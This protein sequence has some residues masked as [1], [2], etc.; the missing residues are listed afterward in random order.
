MRQPLQ[1]IP[2]FQ[3]WLALGALA[4]SAAD[5]SAAVADPP[6]PS[7]T[8]VAV[9]TAM[10]RARAQFDR[11]V[12]WLQDTKG[13]AATSSYPA[14]TEND[15]IE[16][17][18]ATLNGDW[19]L[20]D[21]K[22]WAAGHF[23]GLLWAMHH[24][25]QAASSRGAWADLAK[26][27]SEPLRANVTANPGDMAINCLHVFGPWYQASTASERAQQLGTVVTGSDLLVAPFAP[28]TSPGGRWHTGTGAMGWERRPD[29]NVD[30]DPAGATERNIHY[31][32]IFID[33]CGN[34]EQLLWAAARVPDA[35]KAADYRTKAIAHLVKV[36]SVMGS[37]RRPGTRGIWQRGFFDQDSAI[38]TGLS[39][40]RTRNDP[41]YTLG[42]FSFGQGKQGW[43]DGSTWSRGMGW[44]VHAVGVAYRETGDA[45]LR[46]V[47]IAAN[48]EWIARMPASAGYG[49]DWVAP[50]DFDY[51]EAG[52]PDTERDSSA[53]AMA[54]LGI[55]ATVQGLPQTHAKRRPYL[56]VARRTLDELCG[57]DYLVGA[58]DPEMS[59]LRH[60]CYHHPNALDDS[61]NYDNGLIWGDWFL[62]QSLLTWRQMT[63][64]NSAPTAPARSASTTVG[65]PVAIT[66]G[67]GDAENNPLGWRIVSPPAS[68]TITGTAPNLSYA[69]PA[70]WQGTAT[71]SYVVEDGIEDSAPAVVTV[72]VSAATNQAPTI[73]AIPAQTVAE[74][75]ATAALA[76]T[77]G[78]A[79][80]AAGSLTV[81]AA[82]GNATLVPS[83]GLTLGGSG[84]TRT[85]VVEPAANASG[86]ATITLTVSDGTSTATTSF[87][88]TVTP[89]NDAPTISAVPAQT[90]P[91]DGMTGALAFTVGDVETAA[92]SLTVSATSGNTTL[93]PAA[94]VTLGGSNSSRTVVIK[95]AAGASGSATIT[96]TVSD[97]TSSRTTSFLVTV[98]P[99]PAPEIAIARGATAI[100]DG[101]T[102]AAGSVTM[103][104]T[105]TLTYT[106]ANTGAAALG[107]ITPITATGTNCMVAVTQPGTSVAAGASTTAKL[108]VTP[109]AAGPWNVVVSI[110]T[111]DA[112]EN[113]S[114]WTITG[115][116]TAAAAIEVTIATTVDTA[117]ESPTGKGRVTLTRTGST[118][119]S[120]SVAL[121]LSG[122]ATAADY[123][124]IPTTAVIP[125]GSATLAIDIDPVADG[126]TEGGE[127]VM[128]TLAPPA[129]GA[130]Y[131]LGA[132][133][134]ASVTIF[135]VAPAP[136]PAP[137]APS[138]GD[139]GNGCG[140]GSGF[141]VMLL[142]LVSSLHGMRRGS[143]GAER[144]RR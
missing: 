97:G 38:T 36:G 68:G 3:A 117:V 64:G 7:A 69:P 137:V 12:A 138:D 80:T 113:P 46:D 76:F 141:A 144:K 120:L 127:Q 47:A 57:N 91:V 31:W 143:G 79:E 62:V 13:T 51:A 111:T 21:S 129:S 16:D 128:V 83:S 11:T 63:A 73:T 121:A 53:T 88:L 102:D 125:A 22:F 66:L 124:A 52:N 112:D 135:D 126:V 139:G 142:W 50:W 44:L 93:V 94:G 24:S 107:L 4:S 103:G 115:S 14:F 58:S 40:G 29:R 28:G 131:Q 130:G 123:V 15:A 37:N 90:I 109:T 74:D 61:L 95:P 65:T 9:D 23:P 30:G 89:V 118:A 8:L 48:D 71:F 75:G 105:K 55:L 133:T 34:A 2:V 54:A 27:W 67:G 6:T 25:G 110:A 39:A 1:M 116:A 60:G 56:E 82:S 96:L 119:A 100:A 136:A 86:S 17:H 104:T 122:T 19:R 101:G 92:A 134:Q 81:S 20:A 140:I 85:V 84:S 33:H 132:T 49:S 106:I 32:Q 87:P 70:G 35:A 108:V 43:K 41:N 42:E 99:S 114:N 10:L 98:I 72:T 45:G 18:L 26:A 59:I 77:I 78:D 5:L